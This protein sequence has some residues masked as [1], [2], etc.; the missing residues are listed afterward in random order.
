[1]LFFLSIPTLSVAEG[2]ELVFSRSCRC[3]SQLHQGPVLL[4][5]NHL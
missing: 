1:L 3:F 2:E 5:P 4:M